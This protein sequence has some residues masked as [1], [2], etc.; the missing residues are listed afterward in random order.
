[1][2]RSVAYHLC[3]VVLM[4]EV[5]WAQA[6]CDVVVSW[7]AMRNRGENPGGLGLLPFP[8][9]RELFRPLSVITAR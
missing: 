7:A 2:G 4:N 9:I 5:A 3:Y 8:E 6:G 1:M